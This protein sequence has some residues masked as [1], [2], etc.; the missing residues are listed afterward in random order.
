[1]FLFNIIET[2][3]EH[4]EQIFDIEREA[5]SP[6]WSYEALFEEMSREDS[7]FVVA[8]DYT[9]EPSPCVLGF[10]I[11]R[12]VG[13]DGELLQ[14]A[15]EQSTRHKGVGDSLMMAVLKNAEENELSSVFLEVRSSN[16]IAV[17][18]YEKHGFSTVRVRSDYYNSP[19]EDAL[20]M[21]RTLILK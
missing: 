1:V 19:V 12:Q 18:L 20:I 21:M 4:L 8:M 3:E 11:L 17:K 5:I 6:N 10:A 13:D 15:V 9:E 2:T 7:F 16:T 14:I